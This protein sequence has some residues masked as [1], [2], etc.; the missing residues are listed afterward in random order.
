MQ[1][2]YNGLSTRSISQLFNMEH[3]DFVVKNQVMNF[4]ALINARGFYVVCFLNSGLAFRN[5][6]PS[7][8]PI[9]L[10]LPF[11]FFHATSFSHILRLFDC[12]SR[13][14]RVTK[15]TLYRKPL[16]RRE[17]SFTVWNS[18]DDEEDKW[19]NFVRYSAEPNK[20]ENSEGCQ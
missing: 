18:Y 13:R 17:R 8:Q 2:L 20:N 1:V 6:S 5:F 3:L 10:F 9:T 14:S 19:G 11:T 16:W 15:N 4:F 12:P 7:F